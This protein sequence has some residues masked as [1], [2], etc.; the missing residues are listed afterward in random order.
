MTLREFYFYLVKSRDKPSN[1]TSTYWSELMNSYNGTSDPWVSYF[2][3]GGFRVFN[4]VDG[5]IS[6]RTFTKALFA[7][8]TPYILAIEG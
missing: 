5:T 2:G 4:R 1:E 8:M 3:D 6:G 7:T